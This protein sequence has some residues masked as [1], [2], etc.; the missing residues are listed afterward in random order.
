[1]HDIIAIGDIAVDNF[2]RL[3]EA[4][5]N[6]DIDSHKCTITMAFGDKVPYASSEEVYA[7]GNSPNASVA[8]ARLGLSS[9]I[10]TNLGSDENGARCLAALEGNGVDTSKV[11]VES[12]KPTNYHYVLWYEHDRTILVKHGAY[13]YSLP[14]LGKPKWIYLSSL[15]QHT[16][17]YHGEILKYLSEH[18]DVNL[19]FQ[20]GTFQMKMGIHMLKGIYE[21]ANIFFSNIE[22]AGKILGIETLGITELLKRMHKLGP[23]VVVLTDGPNGAYSYDGKETLF[24]PPYPDQEPAYERTGAGDAFSSTAV[25]AL[26]LGKDLGTALSWGA[27]NAMSVVKQVGAQKGLLTREQLEEYKDKAPADFKYRIFS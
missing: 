18:P 2:L 6:C 26:I 25:S 20:P 14:N 3:E 22:E 19:A 16:E 7:V 17:K 21:R 5:I 27:I 4:A 13:D 12:G 23:Q 8:A 24:I 9:A 11:R 15:G 10:I 1:M